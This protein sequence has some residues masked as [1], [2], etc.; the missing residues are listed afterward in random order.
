LVEPTTIAAD[1]LP[2]G[3]DYAGPRDLAVHRVRSADGTAIAYEVSG[4]GPPL[5]IIGGGMNDRAM[6]TPLATIMSERYTTYNYDRRGRGDSEYGDPTRYTLD[7]EVDDLA[8]VLAVVGEPAYVFANCTGGMIAVL[9]AAAGM[10]MLKLGMFEPPYGG[11]AASAGQVEELNQLILADKRDEVV[12]Y[13]SMNV[14][15]FMTAETVETFKRHPAW[16]AFVSMAPSTYYDAVISRDHT[17]IP[18]DELRQIAV[19]S[20]IMS[21]GESPRYVQDVCQTMAD[22][23][24]DARFQALQGMGHLFD[25]KAGAPPL[26]EFFR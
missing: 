15:R 24:P 16:R 13:F 9:A 18:F 8:A 5:V 17:A 19:P 23:I 3:D 20:L 2:L 22:T 10:P 26:L 25:Q 6:F 1:G 14:V 7:R 12:A 4:D 21:G 11:Q